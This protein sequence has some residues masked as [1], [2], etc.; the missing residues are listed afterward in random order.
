M[1]HAVALNRHA[2]LSLIAELAGCRTTPEFNKLFAHYM[3]E[4]PRAYRDRMLQNRH[5]VEHLD[6][7]EQYPIVV[8]H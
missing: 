2:E 4:K 7:A 1:S 3:N 5:L 6:H 8:A